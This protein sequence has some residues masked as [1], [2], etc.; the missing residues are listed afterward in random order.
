[1]VASLIASAKLNDLG[2]YAYPVTSSNARPTALVREKHATLS[3]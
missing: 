1:M 3:M 2:P